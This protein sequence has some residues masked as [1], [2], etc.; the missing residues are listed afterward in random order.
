MIQSKQRA[1]NSRRRFKMS[2]FQIDSQNIEDLP[3]EKNLK[4]LIFYN[5]SKFNLKLN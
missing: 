5:D 4:E 1:K 3:G 2:N